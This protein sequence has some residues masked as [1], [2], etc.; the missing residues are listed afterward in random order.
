VVGTQPETG[1]GVELIVTEDGTPY[2]DAELEVIDD[3]GNV[4]ADVITDDEG[5]ATLPVLPVGDYTLKV[6]RKDGQVLGDTELSVTFHIVGSDE[7]EANLYISTDQNGK[8]SMS[9]NDMIE[10][11]RSAETGD[12]APIAMLGILALISAAA[13]VVV[14]RKRKDV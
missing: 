1:K 10:N 14:S 9:L 11:N 8:K 13:V 12:T 4:V 2:T 7:E 5:K 3:Q 6:V